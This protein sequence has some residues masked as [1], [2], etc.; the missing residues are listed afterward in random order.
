MAPCSPSSLPRLCR[1]WPSPP[2]GRAEA[3]ERPN[4]LFVFTDDHAT[5]AIGAY[6]SPYAAL[7]PTP[8]IDRLAREG[9]LPELLLHQQHLR[10]QRAVIQT[11]KHSHRNGF[12]DNGDR[13]D[14]DQVTFLKLLQAA[15]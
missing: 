4:I 6:G 7:D 1:S 13:F 11:G 15:G 12:R 9:M 8:N 2:R 5:H 3:T 10:A 14:G